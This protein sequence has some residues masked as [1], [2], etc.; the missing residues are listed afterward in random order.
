MTIGKIDIIINH[1]FNYMISHNSNQF[2]II[3]DDYSYINI[4]IL[5]IAFLI[6]LNFKT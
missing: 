3:I 1:P 6:L 4:Q 2:L 5:E